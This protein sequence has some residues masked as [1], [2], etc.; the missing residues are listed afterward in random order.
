MKTYWW[1]AKN[2]GDTLT[3]H[4][5]EHFIKQ[6]IELAE[7]AD[8]GKLLATGS[9]LHLMQDNDVVWGSGLNKKRRITAKKGVKFLAVR[10][11]ITRWLIRGAKIPQVYGDPGILL[12]LIYNPKIEKKYEV[13][14]LPHYV[15]K[16]F[17]KETYEMEIAEGKAKMIDIQA[18][19]KTV[20]EEVLSCKK[21]ITSS[22]HGLICAEAYGIPVIWVRYSD[23][24]TGG[25]LKFQDYFMGTGRPRQKY[26]TEIPP[27]KDLETKQKILIKALQDYYGPKN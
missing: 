25:P 4:I 6:K 13:G 16:P 2:F 11:P 9:I 22:L 1:P 15:D 7:R 14:I 27:I 5:L 12:P 8:K 23:K 17:A 24:I 3:P 18:D 19:W 26:N 21:I 20:I 10:G